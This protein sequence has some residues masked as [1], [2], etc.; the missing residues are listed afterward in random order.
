MTGKELVLKTLSHETVERPP[1]VPYAGVHAGKLV[2]YTATEV[3]KDGDKLFEAL[4]E[5]RKLYMPDGMPI[6]FDLQ[7]EAEVLGC[8]LIWADDNPPSVISYPLSDTDEIPTKVIGPDDGRVPLIM[9]VSRRVVEEF[10][11]VAVYGLFCGPFTLASHLRGTKLFMD[12]KR[13][14]EHVKQLMAY[15]TKQAIAMCDMY[16]ETGCHVLGPVDPLVSQ[17]SSKHFVE[18]LAEPYTEIFDHIRELNRKSCFF[19]CGN[20]DL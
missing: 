9:D 11:D 3:L 14:P 1:W 4:Q 18:F 5:V 13:N 19:V 20:A 8:D 15:C 12:M 10:G 7:M 6:T 16:A 17:I 2:G